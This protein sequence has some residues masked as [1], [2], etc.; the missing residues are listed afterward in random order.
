MSGMSGMSHGYGA[1][2]AS[3]DGSA[4][5]LVEIAGLLQEG[6][7]DKD[8]GT[9]ARVPHSHHEVGT[10]VDH[11]ARFAADQ[12]QDLVLL[13]TA[14]STA[15]KTTGNNYTA[16]DERTRDDFRAFLDSARCEAP[17]GTHT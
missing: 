12:H 10:E 8:L 15:L 14:L 17:K 7:L 16:V 9:L 2:T 1:N 11:F 5:L 4:N 6:R 13:L 3:I